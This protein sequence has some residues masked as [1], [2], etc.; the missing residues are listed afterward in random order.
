MRARL[1]VE[2][3]NL[4]AKW[5]RQSQALALYRL[6]L[7]LYPDKASRLIVLINVGAAYLHQ[8]KPELAIQVLENAKTHISK[9]LSPK[10]AAG[11]CYNLGMAYRRTRRIADALRQ[12]TE[13]GDIY[14]MSLFARLAEKARNATLKEAGMA[15]FPLKKENDG[16]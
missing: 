4:L 6:A 13:V 15:T 12:F 10:H 11:C 5:G 3:G 14:P 16:H 7:N 8:G 1:L 9:Q 2:L